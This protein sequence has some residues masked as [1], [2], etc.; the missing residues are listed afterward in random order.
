MDLVRR[1]LAQAGEEAVEEITTISQWVDSQPIWLFEL[2]LCLIVATTVLVV[3]VFRR[4]QKIAQNQVDLAKILEQ[5]I[6]RK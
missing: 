2:F 4:Q 3:M 1:M 5:L 6:E